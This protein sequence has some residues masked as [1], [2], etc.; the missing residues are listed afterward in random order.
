MKSDSRF[1]FPWISTLRRASL[2]GTAILLFLGTAAPGLSQAQSAATGPSGPSDGLTYANMMQGDMAL[3]VELQMEHMEGVVKDNPFSSQ[4]SLE[5]NRLLGDG[6]QITRKESGA[7]YRDSAGRMR[8][9][10][11][12]NVPTHN[13][14]NTSAQALKM[15]FLCDPSAYAE[16]ILEP[17]A[18]MAM[19]MTLPNFS[20]RTANGASGQQIGPRPGMFDAGA[21]P[22]DL[23]TQEMDGV[24]A[25]GRR[26][27]RTIPAGQVGND[28][29]MQIT[30][31]RW[32]SSEIHMTVLLK[33]QDPLSGSET[34]RLTDILRH[35]PDAQLFTIPSNYQVIDMP[36]PPLPP[37]MPLKAPPEQ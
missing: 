20:P 28:Q 29:P 32:D 22:E 17:M 5:S 34:L 3:L 15:T 19:K 26:W 1:D 33:R 37:K 6:T 12:L 23:G 30:T 24:I 4:L 10:V 13:T 2:C 25:T 9:E 36:F 21:N 18:K 35:D 8:W 11:T 31:E 16:W 27:T 7:V 14:S